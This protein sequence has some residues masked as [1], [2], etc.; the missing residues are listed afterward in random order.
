[1]KGTDQEKKYCDFLKGEIEK[2]EKEFEENCKDSYEF[3]GGYTDSHD[4][5]VGNLQEERRESL[6]WLFITATERGVCTENLK[7][8]FGKDYQELLEASPL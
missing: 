2:I 4:L 7:E 1:M 6:L 5:E 8:V 3:N